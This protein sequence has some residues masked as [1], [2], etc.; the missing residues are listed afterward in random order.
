MIEQTRQVHIRNIVCASPVSKMILGLA[1]RRMLDP[2]VQMRYVFGKSWILQKHEHFDLL[3][4]RRRSIEV[5][6]NLEV[7][8]ILDCFDFYRAIIPESLFVRSKLVLLPYFVGGINLNF[9]LLVPNQLFSIFFDTLF[10][11]SR[12]LGISFKTPD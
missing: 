8:K 2:S 4:C 12:C 10:E 3:L 5:E 9:A 1:I 6:R 11:S 7:P